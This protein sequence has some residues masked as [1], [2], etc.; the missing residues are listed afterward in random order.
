M[1][2]LFGYEMRQFTISVDCQGK[3]KLSC[4]PMNDTPFDHND[5]LSDPLEWVDRHGDYLFN[6]AF[7]RLYDRTVAE[8]IVQETF[9]AALRGRDRFAG[10]STERTWLVAILKRKIADYLRKTYRSRET[11][12][13]EPED[14]RP[15]REFQESGP[16]KGHW[17]RNAPIDW[18][19]DPGSSLESKEFLDILE[20]CIK[21]LPQR[22]A[23]VFVL[24]EVEEMDSPT[25]CKELEITPTNLWVI[26]HRA[27]QKL[28][29]CLE[30]NW[31]GLP[32]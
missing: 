29:R 26:L 18:G 20:M 24:R 13:P 1:R 32:E 14:S 12:V 17:A 16:W 19:K 8:D 4:S 21:K 27:R 9:L 5:G 3:F 31:I 22:L 15:I 28:R 23:A 10:R 2:R 6:M 7:S 25:V 30:I 11:A